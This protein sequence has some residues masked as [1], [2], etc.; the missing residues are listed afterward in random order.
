[1][2]EFGSHVLTST[3]PLCWTHGTLPHFGPLSGTFHWYILG[4]GSFSH[5]YQLYHFLKKK[6]TVLLMEGGRKWKHTSKH[7]HPIRDLDNLES[8]EASNNSGDGSS[9]G[10]SIPSNMPT[11][12]KHQCTSQIAT[13]LSQTGIF[14][15][16]FALFSQHLQNFIFKILSYQPHHTR[17]NP[18]R[19][20]TLFTDNKKTRVLS[21]IK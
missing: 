2:S 8:E 13:R 1:M 4:F 9:S 6:K 5:F 10:D 12:R 7:S 15:V 11:N 16:L 18:F 20:F 17:S 19:L 3:F 21:P 14:H